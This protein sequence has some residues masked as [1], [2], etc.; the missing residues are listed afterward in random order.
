M[1]EM[2]GKFTKEPSFVTKTAISGQFVKGKWNSKLE[3]TFPFCNFSYCIIL[4]KSANLMIFVCLCCW[5]S[6]K[7][8]SP[9]TI[10]A[11]SIVSAK[12]SR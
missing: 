2:H 5:S 10:Y 12:D 3:H 8:L 4:R 7:S 1:S 11:A 9:E 6:S